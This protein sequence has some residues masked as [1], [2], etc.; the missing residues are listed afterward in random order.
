MK[1]TFFFFIAIVITIIASVCHAPTTGFWIAQQVDLREKGED[2]SFQMDMVLI[3]KKGRERERK[4]NIIRKNFGGNDKLLLKFTY[5]N[6]IKGTSFLVWEHQEKDNERFLYLPALGRVRRIATSEKDENFAGTDFSYED[7]SGRKLENY[8]YELIKEGVTYNNY[9]CYLL[10]SYPK[11]MNAKYPM[12][13]SWVRMDN[14]VVIKAQYYN[15]QEEIEKTFQVLKLEKV[16]D[17]WTSLELSMEN[18]K[19]KHKTVSKVANVAYNQG[20]PDVRFDKREL[21]K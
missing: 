5:P 13:Q 14:F 20:I 9:A 18:H 16:D 3:D 4:L 2:A 19:M 8:T 7:I 17:I 21:M 10:A 1:Y 6:D 15:K 12:I 11:E